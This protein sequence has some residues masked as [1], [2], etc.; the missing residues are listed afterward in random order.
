MRIS[1]TGLAGVR[2]LTPTRHADSRGYFVEVW[3][4]KAFA[5]AGIDGEI[6][7]ENLAWS[8]AAGTIR[9][10]HFQISPHAQ[11]KLVRV[12]RGSV[13]DVVVDLR[14]GSPRFGGHFAIEL[15]RRDGR[16][17]WIP[18]GCAHGYCTLEPDCELAYGVT[19]PYRPAAERGI[20]WDDPALAIPWPV[21]P[22]RAV[23]SERDR[24]LPRLAELPAGDL[25][26][27]A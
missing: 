9:G 20:R 15:S 24:S 14:P 10:L 6:V 19:A 4:R 7:Q 11:G 1:E 3:S 23:I 2:L 16:Q 12:I 17:L 22:E 25:A 27:V 26:A 21:P 18:P 5:A 13:L 8:A